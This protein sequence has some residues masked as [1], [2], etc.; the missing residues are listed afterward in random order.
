PQLHEPEVP[1]PLRAAHQW[2]GTGVVLWVGGTLDERALT[3]TATTL[4]YAGVWQL[5]V[6]V[7]ATLRRTS[8]WNAVVLTATWL[9]TTTILPAI[10]NLAVSAVTPLPDGVA[11]TLAQRQEMNAGWDRPKEETMAPFRAANPTYASV[12]VPPDRFSWP[13]YYA[14]HDRGDAAVKPALLQYRAALAARSDTARL[15]AM[16]LPPVAAQRTFDAIAGTDLATMLAYRDS[17]AEYHAV[18]KRFMYPRI[19]ANERWGDL[20]ID[21]IPRHRFTVGSAPGMGAMLPLFAFASVL[22]LIAWIRARGLDPI[23]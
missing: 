8:T 22:A 21:A 1:D 13:W 17:V 15:A 19:M 4:L 16:L 7:V 23:A 9:A 2:P 10:V 18:L 20:Q 12:S 5:G 14:M 3:W 11:L 6:L